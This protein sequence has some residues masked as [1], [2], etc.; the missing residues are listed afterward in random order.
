MPYL[1]Q[2]GLGMPDRAYYLDPSS[3]R[4]AGLRTKYQ[5]HIAAMFKL[6]GYGGLDADARAAKVFALE[7][8]IATSHATRADSA[9]VLKA[10]NTWTR[11]DFEAKAPGMDWNRLLQGRAPGRPGQVHR[12][13]SVG[14]ERRSGAG[15]EDRPRHLEGLAGLPP[16]Q[17]DGRRAAE[18]LRRPALR[19][20]RQGL[21]GTPQQS[22]RWK[23]ALGA[24]NEAM[25]EA[26]GKM[27]VAKYFPAENKAR[28]QQMVATSSTPSASASTSS[29]GWRRPPAPRPRKS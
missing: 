1:L 7:V 9:D 18:G 28:L 13:A 10:D 26:V 8:D 22:L 23:R 11:K 3:E 17:P 29:T 15:A 24:T 5:Q 20:L 12:L 16:H 4:M 2:G 21:S 25:D 27:Y 19:L 6:A 14:R